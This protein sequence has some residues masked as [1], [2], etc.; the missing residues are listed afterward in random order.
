MSHANATGIPWQASAGSSY[1]ASPGNVATATQ[2]SRPFKLE[3]FDGFSATVV[4]S[5]GGSPV[6]TLVLE[7][8]NDDVHDPPSSDVDSSAMT[9]TEIA[10]SAE[11]VSADGSVTWNVSGAYY[12]WVRV[13]W[14]KTSGT[15]S[16]VLSINGKGSV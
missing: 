16:L 13:R 11:A 2:L 8:S 10:D 15:G 3:Q 14:T 5:G 4:V 12:L 6:G 9:F 7:A 1:T